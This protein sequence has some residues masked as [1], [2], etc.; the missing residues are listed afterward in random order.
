M[1]E[2]KI[3]PGFDGKDFDTDSAALAIARA[4]ALEEKVKEVERIL[5][6]HRIGWDDFDT[7]GVARAIVKFFMETQEAKDESQDYDEIP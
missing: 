3:R 2:D 4:Q 7:A 6:G 1:T 5:D